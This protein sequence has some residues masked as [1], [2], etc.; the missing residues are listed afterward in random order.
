MTNSTI[1]QKN[2]EII[3]QKLKEKFGKEIEEL[4]KK[5]IEN[6]RKTVKKTD[7][8]S[9]SSNQ[10]ILKANSSNQPILKANSSRVDTN[11][12]PPIFETRKINNSDTVFLLKG[13]GE[14]VP[15]TTFVEITIQTNSSDAIAMVTPIYN[16]TSNNFYNVSQI[17]N[18]K[19]KVY[20]NPGKFYWV[21]HM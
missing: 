21:V 14:I 18:N 15:G 3:R 5:R 11:R 12:N 9:S 2:K 20:G 17:E 13:I 6:E 16:G 10:P 19:F 8:G 4:E 7:S 1:S